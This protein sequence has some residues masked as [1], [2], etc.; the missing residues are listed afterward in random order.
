M[1]G[2]LTRAGD[3]GSLASAL[4]L[5]ELGELASVEG[6]VQKRRLTAI[7]SFVDENPEETL[8][9]IQSWLVKES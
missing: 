5:E 4:T 9:V 1:A 2:V 6:G 7:E 8:Q 3:P